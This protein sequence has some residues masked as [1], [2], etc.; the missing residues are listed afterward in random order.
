M[1]DEGVRW[2]TQNG[3]EPTVSNWLQLNYL[4]DI[5]EDLDESP[6]LLAEIPWDELRNDTALVP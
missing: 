6:E 1:S 5:P 4:G 2:L 3:F